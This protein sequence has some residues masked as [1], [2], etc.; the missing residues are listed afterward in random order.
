MVVW[1][2]CGGAVVVWWWCVEGVVVVWWWCGG[3]VVVVWWWC[4]GGVV[5]GGCDGDLAVVIKNINQKAQLSAPKPPNN[6]NHT[7]T[8]ENHQAPKH[9]ATP[10]K[11]YLDCMKTRE[12]EE[13]TRHR[14]VKGKLKV[15]A[16]TTEAQWKSLK[17]NLSEVPGDQATEPLAV[18]ECE[19]D[20]RMRPKLV[21]AEVQGALYNL[22][23]APIAGGLDGLDGLVGWVGWVGWLGGLVGWV[24]WVGWVSWVGGLV[25][26]DGWWVG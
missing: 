19:N 15:E 4:D 18:A 25:G 26:L 8:S 9:H 24:G 13:Q 16:T 10:Q 12:G 6:N 17:K 1:W 23:K 7:S 20:L 3:G 11:D 22:Q 2:W 14:V 21:P 5:V